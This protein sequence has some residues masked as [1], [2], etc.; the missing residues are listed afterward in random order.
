VLVNL[1]L[2]GW[3]GLSLGGDSFDR[4]L[5]QLMVAVIAGHFLVVALTISDRDG[6]YLLYGFPLILLFAACGASRLLST[7]PRSR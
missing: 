6:R 5:S 4:P 3:L 7:S 1:I 2:L